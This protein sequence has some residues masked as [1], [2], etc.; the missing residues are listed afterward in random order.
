MMLATVRR[1]LGYDMRGKIMAL[2]GTP[3][4]VTA[5][6]LNEVLQHSTHRR[7]DIVGVQCTD[8]GEGTGIFGQ[9]ARLQLAIDDGSS[10]SV[11][12][13][14]PCTE[15][16]NLAVAQAL[17]LY[18]REITMFDQVIGS[19]PLSAVTCLA[20]VTEPDGSFVLILEDL[21]AHWEVGDQVV[22][23][24]LAQ[25][26]AIVDALAAFHAHW[27]EH[28]HLHTMSWLPTQDAPQYLAVVPEIYRVGL[29]VLQQHWADRLPAEAIDLAGRLAPRFEEIMLRTARGPN[30]ITHGD[31]R[32]DNVFF[33]RANPSQVKFID[34][35]LSM[36]G[37]GVADL[38]YLISNSVPHSIAS[39]H[40][41][42]LI[43]RWI[44]GLAE[45]GVHYELD[46]AIQHYREA[47]L[48]FLSG[49]MSL[50]GT[51]DSGN[52]RGAAMVEAYATRSLHHV[53]DCGAA[54]VL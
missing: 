21:A 29:G 43:R 37:R 8:I 1:L 13:K 12:V 34:F 28:P 54:E 39:V 41:R 15:P 27:W 44:A 33:S 31:T 42:S 30:T 4:A 52:E 17:G 49:A 22:G 5:D 9:I 36:R 2:P 51:F 14:M 3:S 48:Y 11:V 32:L 45:H 19:S 35:Q 7:G 40:W 24:T 50:I 20:A 38:A 46:D 47:A 26:E 53:V 25:A 10:M 18:Q 16:A 6:W 23:A